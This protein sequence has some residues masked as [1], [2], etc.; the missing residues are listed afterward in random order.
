M[1][2][3]DFDYVYL[4]GFASNPSSSKAQFYKLK[5][6]LHNVNVYTPDLNG[7]DFSQLTLTQAINQTQNII[8]QCNKPVVLIGSSMG[9]LISALVAE[10]NLRVKKI[11]L[12]APAFKM[13]RL[14]QEIT[15][16]KQRSN[17]QAIG[18]ENVY[19]YGYNKEVRLNYQFYTDLFKHN[20][21][22]FTR[23][24]PCLIF[25]GIHDDVVPIK[26]SQE[27]VKA[28]PQAQLISL[29]DDHS[30]SKY[31]EPMWQLSC[32]FIQHK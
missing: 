5:L 29:D 16:V 19:H 30:V 11:I 18:Y 6:T 20:D 3:N 13:S 23:N 14:W 28:H 27:Y 8:K 31:L 10:N 4:H 7:S 1:S 12:L 25:H 24:L 15:S 9:G 2:I 26:S 22:E 32:E 21:S 17:W